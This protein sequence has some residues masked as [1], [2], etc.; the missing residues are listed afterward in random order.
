[1]T[2]TEVHKRVLV[3]GNEGV[4]LFRV[5]AQDIERVVALP[6]IAPDFDQRLVGALD[7]NPKDSVLV[8]YSGGDAILRKDII[9]K[10]DEPDDVLACVQAKLKQYFPDSP[11]RGAAICAPR[12][13]PPF[14]LFAAIGEDKHL[15]KVSSILIDAGT[16]IKAISLL[17]VES[18]DL[19][20]TLSA[21]FITGKGQLSNWAI[22]VD[23][24]ETGGL[25]QIAIKNGSL[26]LT[27]VTPL[28]EGNVHGQSWVEEVWREL[29]A[30]L[31]YLA[32]FGYT[33]EQGLDVM[34]L[35][36]DTEKQLFGNMSLPATNFCYL[37]VSAV[38][39]ALDARGTSL[40]D[41]NFGDSV[42]ALFAS[43]K[44][45]L[46]FSMTFQ[47]PQSVTSN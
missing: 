26:A 35:C 7:K 47:K 34:I 21:K 4:V 42:H 24:H 32:R 29:R 40:S 16:T 9:P 46:S 44:S 14:F 23:R 17:A 22:L 20:A 37:T 38:L 13:E 2:S 1:M 5:T 15:D 6:L 45:M 39:A 18:A 43:R 12:G 31:V 11:R 36:S 10:F 30:T 19:V 28:P 33:A 41:V 27:R 3:V 8:L 25:R